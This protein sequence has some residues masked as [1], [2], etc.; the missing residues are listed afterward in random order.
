MEING[1]EL[2]LASAGGNVEYNNQINA[3]A[4]TLTA[5]AEGGGVGGVTIAVGSDTNDVTVAPGGLLRVQAM[6]G[7]TLDIAGQTL[8]GD[9]KFERGSIEL[10]GGGA[11]DRI[12]VATAQVNVPSIAVAEQLALGSYNYD[13]AGG[14]LG[15]SSPDLLAGV[16]LT[17]G[18][19]GAILTIANTAYGAGGDSGLEIYL[20]DTADGDG[21]VDPVPD[22]S[23]LTFEGILSSP[24]PNPDIPS[25]GDLDIGDFNF[26]NWSAL[27]HDD[28]FSVLFE[29]VMV[30]GA[31]D[32]YTFGTA[33]DDGST[34][35]I[36]LDRNGLYEHTGALGDEMI[37]DNK[38]AHGRQER[39]GGAHLTA[40]AY[41]IAVPFEER[42][43]GDNIEGKW[44]QGAGLSYGAL[45]FINPAGPFWTE[46][47][48]A[49]INAPNTNLDVT[50]DAALALNSPLA[51]TLGDVVLR[52]DATLTILPHAG[53]TVDDVSGNGSIVGDFLVGGEFHAG[54]SPG[55][56]V[57][58]GNVAF[59]PGSIFYVDVE[60]LIPGDEY[61]QAVLL[62]GVLDISNAALHVQTTFTSGILPG[63]TLML[64]NNQGGTVVGNFLPAAT[65][66]DGNGVYLWDVVYQGDDVFLQN[67]YIPEPAT[68]TLLGLGLLAARRRRRKR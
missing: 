23:T 44:G 9:F 59:L 55:L 40:G 20:H 63:D 68:L 1:G 14:P 52:N 56:I 45:A 22:S 35:W 24:P 39:M 41:K 36:D 51:A 18:A 13:V 5:G 37:V 12:S 31:E 38:G 54:E 62:G 58:D 4:G 17:L 32:D 16:D 26:G 48:P 30:V 3:T 47:A 11:V 34:F 49:P 28:S 50:A 19:P 46:V 27:T 15:V 2:V 57:L 67:T 29:G 6:D 42:G 66:S 25:N 53:L 43:G 64:I 60:G 65:V 33:S 10:S 61:S 21:R 7:I 8:G